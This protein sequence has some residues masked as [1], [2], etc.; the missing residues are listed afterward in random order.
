[1]KIQV[2]DS[3]DKILLGMHERYLLKTC[4][5]SSLNHLIMGVK[6]KGKQKPDKIPIRNT[7]FGADSFTFAEYL[8][9][10]SC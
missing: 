3:A 2:V 4:A 8:F 6:K 5:G 1:M 7:T 9:P 10:S